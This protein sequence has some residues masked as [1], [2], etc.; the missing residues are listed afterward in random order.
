[1]SRL[2]NVRIMVLDDHRNMRMLWRGMLLGFGIRNVIEAGSARDALEQ[3]Q[4]TDVDAIIVDHHL[5]DMTGSEFVEVL[6]KGK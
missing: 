2:R 3:L 6:R 4:Q 5:G 1:M